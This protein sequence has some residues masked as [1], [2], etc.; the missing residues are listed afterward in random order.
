MNQIEKWDKRFLEM[1]KTISLWSKDPSTKVGCV[2]KHNLNEI[3]SL[4]YNGFP[5]GDPDSEEEYANRQIK[6][7]KIVHAEINAWFFAKRNGFASLQGCT[8]YTYPFQPCETCTNTLILLKPTRIVSLQPTPEQQS[9]WDES[10]KR[11]KQKFE[12][13]LIEMTIYPKEFL[14]E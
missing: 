8:V 3:V 1:S 5:K 11:A 14:G 7:S 10:F 4:G 12:S 6:Y 9:R 2:I 13:N